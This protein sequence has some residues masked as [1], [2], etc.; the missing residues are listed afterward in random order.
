[1]RDVRANPFGRW[2]SLQVDHKI[3]KEWGG[4]DALENL[5]PLCEACN[6]GKKNLFASYDKH[7][8]AIRAAIHHDSVH[9]RIGELLRALAPAWVRSDVIDMVASPPG[10][11]QEDW[12]RRIRELRDL[13][14][15]YETRKRREN[16]RVWS[17]YR[18]TQVAEWPTGNLRTAIARGNLARRRSA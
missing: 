15:D 18:M 4:S 12:Q 11:Y 8:D 13:G 9:L 14:W 1:L 17:Y 2:H 6:R 10:D 3:P 7:A 5:Q 16:G